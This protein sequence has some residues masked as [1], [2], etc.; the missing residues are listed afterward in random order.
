[1]VQQKE[2]HVWACLS[3]N[4]GINDFTKVHKDREEE[5]LQKSQSYGTQSVIRKPKAQQNKTKQNKGKYF[6]TTV[7]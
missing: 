4:L 7:S 2:R 1:M 6:W 5:D 3:G